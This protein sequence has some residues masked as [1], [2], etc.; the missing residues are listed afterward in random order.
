MNYPTP[1]IVAQSAV[2]PLPRWALLMLCAAYV[3]F[4]F[5]GRD[6]WRNSD[7][8]AFGY[9]HELAL[10]NTSWLSPTLAGLAPDIDG[11]LPYW[12]GAWAIRIAPDWIPMEFAARLPFVAML[13]LTLA[14]T[15]YSVYYLA[16]QPGA[17]PVAFAFGG[18]AYPLDYARAVG[19]A[20]LLALI[21]SLG[22]AQLSHETTG[23]L[24]QLCCTALVFFSAS[25][26]PHRRNVSALYGLAGLLG[27]SLSGAPT[28]SVLLGLG[29]AV[30]AG[31]SGLAS[32]S[33]RIES[34]VILAMATLL[35]AA[36]AW[37]L[38][39]WRFNAVAPGG[40]KEF[41]S[42]FRLI[43]W[44]CWPAWPLALWTVWRWRHQ[45]FTREWNRHLLLPLWFV[46]VALCAMTTSRPSDRALL[47]GLPALAALAAF[48]LPTLRRSIG[49][50]IDW[51]TLIF[52]SISAITIWVVW[53]SVQTGF[54]PKPAANVARLAPDYVPTFSLLAFILGL[55]ATIAWC[56]LV[57]WRASRNRDA[58]WKSLI[59]PASG[60][61]LG[62]ILLMTIWLPMLNYG[63][64]MAP[65]IRPVVAL[66]TDKSGCVGGYGLSRAQLAALT[67]YGQIQVANARNADH[68]EWIVADAATIPTISEVWPKD[69]WEQVGSVARPTD[70]NDQLVVL[71][72]RAP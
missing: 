53:I 70:K 27:L 12:L 56:A 30:I 61:T 20:G 68:C 59:L 58:I 42:Y 32:H 15:W 43:L 6:P 47:L 40:F 37:A 50:L 39:L 18:E 57:W 7:I 10:G 33:K 55:G 52:F 69:Q 13:A 45:I 51:F 36:V 64:S 4:G 5:V 11:L 66:I 19:D 49:A 16:R 25:S 28:V 21:A 3:I 26:I 65:Q 63:R 38:G 17:Q 44:F 22:L 62:W 8:T 23:Y 54:P 34:A 67:Y 24:T 41:Q 35:A 14:A 48:A 31:N 46:L 60:A 29:S 9:M 72:R 71:R 1:A 2:R